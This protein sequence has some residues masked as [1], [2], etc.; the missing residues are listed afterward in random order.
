MC[1]VHMFVD[2]Q[3]KYVHAIGMTRAST[4]FQHHAGKSMIQK[5]TTA[6]I[7]SSEAKV[8]L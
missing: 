4:Y 7:Q 2:L 8:D 3:A 5:R 1:T 6:I